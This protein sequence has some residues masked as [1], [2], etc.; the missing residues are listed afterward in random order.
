MNKTAH[1]DELPLATPT[2]APADIAAKPAKKPSPALA[3]AGPDEFDWDDPDE[4]AIV[5]REQRATAVY[6]NKSGEAIIRQR[7][8]A[9][10]DED[11]FVFVTPENEIAFME[12]MAARL[13]K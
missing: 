6:R 12:G 11:S 2:N 13:K 3:Q 5:L 1:I 10:P 4:E 9:C 8:A 7:S